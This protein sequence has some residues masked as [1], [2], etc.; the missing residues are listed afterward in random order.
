M[1][2]RMAFLLTLLPLQA[3]AWTHG[4]GVTNCILVNTGNCILVSTGNILLVQ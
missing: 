3:S 2:I 1:L 4:S